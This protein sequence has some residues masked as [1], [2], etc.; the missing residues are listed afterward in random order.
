M[1]HWDPNHPSHDSPAQVER[2]R[3]L[4]NLQYLNTSNLLQVL[5]SAAKTFEEIGKIK[6]DTWKDM[7]DAFKEA[8]SVF[9][10]M[11]GVGR[12]QAAVMKPMTT[13]MGTMGFGI[14]AMMGPSTMMLQQ[15]THAIMQPVR[16]MTAENQTGSAIGG[17]V[18]MGLGAIA[19]AYAGGQAAAGAA[20]G[21]A[22]G[23]FIGGGIEDIFTTTS[24]EVS[25]GIRVIRGYMIEAMSSGMNASAAYTYVSDKVDLPSRFYGDDVRAAWYWHGYQHF[26]YFQRDYESM[27]GGRQPMDTGGTPSGTTGGSTP[28]VDP[29]Y[30]ERDYMLSKIMRYE[31]LGG[32]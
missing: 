1:S 26:S 19:G 29:S 8:G 15:A 24:G 4:S 9:G 28:N 2:N 5:G 22:F 6:K 14:E 31:R 17:I 12:L 23:S 13:A 20:L 11:A 32:R 3:S 25:N 16:Q 21:G 27:G 30:N 10:Q 18:G 7:K